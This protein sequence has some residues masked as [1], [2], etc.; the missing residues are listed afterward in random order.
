[1]RH[2]VWK[3]IFTFMLV[4]VLTVCTVAVLSTATAAK[5]ETAPA[6]YSQKVRE[7][8]TSAAVTEL[9]APVYEDSSP[10]VSI[11]AFVL[12]LA[13]TGAGCTLYLRSRRKEQER[14]TRDRSTELSA[15]ER[16]RAERRARRQYAYRVAAA[17]SIRR[18]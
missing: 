6:R 15:A 8:Q 18:I 17:P 10:L 3:G 5:A 7:A 9:S 2:G 13:V 16:R 4:L 11:G 14:K 1:M 12:I